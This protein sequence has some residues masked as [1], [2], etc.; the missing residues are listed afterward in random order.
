MID[1]LKS[2]RYFSTNCSAQN[3]YPFFIQLTSQSVA[4][5]KSVRGISPGSSAA[6]WNNFCPTLKEQSVVDVTSPLLAQPIAVSWQVNVRKHFYGR[7]KP[8]SAVIMRVSFTPLLA[9]YG[10][11]RK[12]YGIA[13]YGTV[14]YGR[15]N[16][17]NI[18][19]SCME[20]QQPSSTMRHFVEK[21]N[22][23]RTIPRFT[24]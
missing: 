17:Y 9:A 23:K 13:E 12:A 1:R 5:L 7:R 21:I 19:Y 16:F 3:F 18:E 22:E 8:S 2:I 6:I 20:A 4:Q 15:S 11:Q 14:E 24:Y 10:V